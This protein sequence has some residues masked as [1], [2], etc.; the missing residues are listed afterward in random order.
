MSDEYRQHLAS[1]AAAAPASEAQAEHTLTL[2]LTLFLTLTLTLA[3]GPQA[4][5]LPVG[6]VPAE[7]PPGGQ[8]QAAQRHLVLEARCIYTY[9]HVYIY[10]FV[11]PP[12]TSL[13]FWVYDAQ[14][15][16]PSVVLKSCSAAPRLLLCGSS[17]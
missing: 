6:Q 4:G 2:T 17:R 1:M 10:I 12:P 3:R 14:R 11:P 8:V 5:R 9:I 7:R 15:P 16:S 13:R